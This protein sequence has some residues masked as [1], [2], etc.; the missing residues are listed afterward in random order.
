MKREL[1]KAGQF[2][3]DFEE[4][5]RWYGQQAGTEVSERFFIAVKQTLDMLS[6]HPGLGRRCRFPQRELRGVHSFLVIRPFNRY[7]I[8]YRFDE[9]GLEALRLIHGARDLPRQLLERPKDKLK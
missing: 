6:E 4:Q 8:F 3:A 2:I 1:R 5:A 9:M 7:L